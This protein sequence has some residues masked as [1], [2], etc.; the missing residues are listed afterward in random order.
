MVQVP[1]PLTW[2]YLL[3]KSHAA[4]TGEKQR[5]WWSDERWGTWKGIQS[6]HVPG[7]SPWAAAA[8]WPEYIQQTSVSITGQ[9]WQRQE[10][11]A[12]QPGPSSTAPCFPVEGTQRMT[13]ILFCK[14]RL[15]AQHSR[16]MVYYTIHYQVILLP[17]I[18]LCTVNLLSFPR[19][20]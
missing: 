5:S 10:C 15:E 9:G 6:P 16:E 20:A 4:P 12:P 11:P 7:V 2:A 13:P 14:L 18:Q 8:Q 19:E 3:Q 17:G 1:L